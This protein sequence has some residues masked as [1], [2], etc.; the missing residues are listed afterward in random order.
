[1]RVILKDGKGGTVFTKIFPDS[2]T[3]AYNVYQ[4]LEVKSY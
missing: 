3:S 2:V 4:F 1:M